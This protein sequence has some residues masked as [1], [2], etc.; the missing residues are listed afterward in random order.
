MMINFRSET[1]NEFMKSKKSILNEQANCIE[2]EKRRSNA[3]LSVKQ[4]E[5]ETLKENLGNKT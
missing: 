4:N 2:S 3:L 5:I 1:L